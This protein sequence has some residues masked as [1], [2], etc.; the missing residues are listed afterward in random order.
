MLSFGF[1]RSKKTEPRP[2]AEQR[3]PAKPAAPRKAPEP[4]APV[5][6]GPPAGPSTPA[7]APGGDQ[8]PAETPTEQRKAPRRPAALVPSVTGLRI[9]PHGAGAMLVNI[10][11]TGLLAECSVR[12]QPGSPVTVNFEGTFQPASIDGR[13]ARSAVASVA[14]DGSL[15]YHAGINFSVPI[16]LEDLPEA[17]PAPFATPVEAAAPVAAALVTAAPVAA[18]P[19][20]ADEVPVPVLRN[21][22]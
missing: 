10:S 3:P 6:A 16:V 11:R 20:A 7:E 1:G 18:V 4:A 19:V 13:V 15:R 17:E 9:S 5:Q 8:P 21:R 22:W 14:A 12:L 2:A